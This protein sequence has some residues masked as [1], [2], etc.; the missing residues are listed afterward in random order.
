[1]VWLVEI[2]GPLFASNL[3]GICNPSCKRT[4]G[5]LGKWSYNALGDFDSAKLQAKY[6]HLFRHL[7]LIMSVEPKKRDGP[8]RA[9]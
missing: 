2:H 1:M 6:E 5:A 8:R 4:P 3:C 9:Q 7:N